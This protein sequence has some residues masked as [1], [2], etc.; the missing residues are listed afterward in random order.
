MTLLHFCWFLDVCIFGT[1]PFL[2]LFYVFSVFD[3]WMLALFNCLSLKMFCVFGYI[4][5]LDVA[6]FDRCFFRG[7]GL[8]R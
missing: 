1:I 2:R 3:F 4:L 7:V 5:L 8:F 6:V